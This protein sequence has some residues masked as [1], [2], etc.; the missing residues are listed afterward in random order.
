MQRYND[1]SNIKRIKRE[2]QDMRREP[3]SLISA[4][5][6]VINGYQQILDW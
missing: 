2:L 5:P 3:L 6:K 1:P 4:G